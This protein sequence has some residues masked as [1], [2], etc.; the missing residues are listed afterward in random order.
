VEQEDKSGRR[1]QQP[2]HHER[3][4]PPHFAG[5]AS[6]MPGFPVNRPAF[7]VVGPLE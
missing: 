7:L 6:A 5:R 2:H 3:C 4:C 1:D